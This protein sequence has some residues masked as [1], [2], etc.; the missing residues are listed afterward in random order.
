MKKKIKI[1]VFCYRKHKLF[2]FLNQHEKFLLQKFKFAYF[3]NV[4]FLPK[5]EIILSQGTAKE[6]PPEYLRKYIFLKPVFLEVLTDCLQNPQGIL[7]IKYQG[8]HG[9]FLPKCTL[10]GKRQIV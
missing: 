8:V 5:I 2:I 9:K 10:K 3:G 4:I 1:C 6:I 7:R